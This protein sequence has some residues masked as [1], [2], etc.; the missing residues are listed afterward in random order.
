MK[1][2]LD[3]ANSSRGYCSIWHS[4][5]INDMRVPRMVT[6]LL[7]RDLDP[8]GVQEEKAHTLKIRTY[9][10][11]GPNHVWHHDG[12]EKLKPYRFRYMAA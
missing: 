9:Q 8:A 4:I 11:T 10:N 5:Q 2:L 7:A 1:V 6:E 3:G 12:F